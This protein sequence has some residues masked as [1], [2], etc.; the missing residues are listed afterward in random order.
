MQ[1]KRHGMEFIITGQC[2]RKA[3]MSQFYAMQPRKKKISQSFD[4][5]Q[6]LRI[7][8]VGNQRHNGH[9][10]NVAIWWCNKGMP[11]CFTTTD[12]QGNCSGFLLIQ[13][14]LLLCVL[15]GG[16]TL[17]SFLHIHQVP[18]TQVKCAPDFVLQ[19]CYHLPSLSLIKVT[20]EVLNRAYQCLGQFYQPFALYVRRY[21]EKVRKQR[22]MAAT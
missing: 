17:K 8:T 5:V 2:Q 22:S 19:C 10:P 3:T 1:C 12:T 16:I 14:T 20:K 7:H 4:D 13:Y 15:K 21:V 11:L 18:N 9:V 6:I